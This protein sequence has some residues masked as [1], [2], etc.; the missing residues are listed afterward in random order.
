MPVTNTDRR[1]NCCG[2]FTPHCVEPNPCEVI[3]AATFVQ[4]EGAFN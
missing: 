1:Q 2:T 3:W 4:P